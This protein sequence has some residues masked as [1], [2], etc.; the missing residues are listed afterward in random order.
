MAS[1]AEDEKAK[2][3]KAD[4]AAADKEAAE[5]AA[6]PQAPVPS[7]EEADAIKEAFVEG[8]TREAKA[9]TSKANYKTR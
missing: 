9:S 8:E 6:E 2:K 3:A 5:K 7:Q 4:K 1:E